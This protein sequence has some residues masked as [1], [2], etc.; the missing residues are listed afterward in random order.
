MPDV[1]VV[2]IQANWGTAQTPPTGGGGSA[3][4]GG[5]TGPGGGGGTYPGGWGPGNYVPSGPKATD[6][7]LHVINGVI[8][9][10]RK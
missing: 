8:T 4:G 7:S 2:K 5:N 6:L 1:A 3:T 9:D 10:T